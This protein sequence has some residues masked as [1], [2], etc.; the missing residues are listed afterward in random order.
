M[1]EPEFDAVFWDIGGVILRL[2]SVQR[3]H[4]AFVVELLETH[5]S[6]YS[7]EEALETWRSTL[8]SYFRDTEGTNYRPARGGYQR[9]VDAILTSSAADT[10][11]QPLF[12]QVSE[13]YLE[14]N[15]DAI[16]AI[17]RLAETPLHLGV[18]SDVDHEEGQQILRTFGVLSLFDSFTSSEAVGRKKP[19][20]AMF[21]TA[22]EK[23]DV[24]PADAV[25]IGDRYSHD[26]QGGHEAGMTTIAYGADDGPAVD[27]RIDNLRDVLTIVGL[28][29]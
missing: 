27:Y 24:D 3:G 10:D 13:T 19:D 12:E 2:E 25:M 23:A 14:P 5:D 21:E 18:I 9:A 29:E 7:P 6:P 20:P 1:N 26:M 8:G 28:D 16:E 11:W 15:P 22:L 4:R 17:E